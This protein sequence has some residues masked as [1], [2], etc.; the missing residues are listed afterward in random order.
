MARVEDAPGAT[1]TP[2]YRVM[3]YHPNILEKFIALRNSYWEEGILDHALKE[4]VRLLSANINNC[5]H[6]RAVRTDWGKRAGVEEGLLREIQDFESNP[7]AYTDK[8]LAALRF[9]QAFCYSVGWVEAE[10]FDEAKEHLSD[11]ELVELTFCLWQFVG[12]NYFMHA[13]GIGEEGELTPYYGGDLAGMK[14][15]ETSTA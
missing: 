8:E 2:F 10:A 3:G 11:A 5:E 7:D 12:G 4:K 9:T 1:G 13:L 6:C 14:W 15:K